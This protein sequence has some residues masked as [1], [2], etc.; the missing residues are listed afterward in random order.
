MATPRQL[1]AALLVCV[2]AACNFAR[3]SEPAFSENGFTVR[4]ASGHL[5]LENASPAP[6]HYV[7]LE[8]ETSALVDLYFGPQEWPSIAP[9]GEER[10]PNADLMGYTPDARQARVYW[11][12]GGQYGQH[13]VVDLR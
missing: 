12:T 4:A 5:I 11:W 6:I 10:I 8:E 3:S 7:A 1:S 2:A 9:G 13:F